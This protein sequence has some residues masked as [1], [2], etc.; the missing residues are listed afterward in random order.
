MQSDRDS[1]V[2]LNSFQYL[3]WIKGLMGRLNHSRVAP[4]WRIFASYQSLR[5]RRPA[6]LY[7]AA[8]T[9]MT[10]YQTNCTRPYSES[11]LR[12]STSLCH[13]CSAN[14][15]SSKRGPIP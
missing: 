4:P 7:L 9:S 8:A 14:S 1:N 15:A 2:R 12:R 11:S 5:T 6:G 3:F 10:A 13:P